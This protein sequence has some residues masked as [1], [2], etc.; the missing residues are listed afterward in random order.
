MLIWFFPFPLLHQVDWHLAFKLLCNPANRQTKDTDNIPSPH[1]QNTIVKL[2]KSI[3]IVGF[4][5]LLIFLLS[6]CFSG[7]LRIGNLS[8]KHIQIVVLW[9]QYKCFTL[10]NE[11]IIFNQVS[12]RYIN[13]LCVVGSHIK[14]SLNRGKAKDKGTLD[15][16]G[17]SA[18]LCSLSFMMHLRR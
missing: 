15:M 3:L 18:H 6:S 13:A 5:L 10:E 7:S 1:F 17:V 2:L 12:P 16:Q 14:H 11:P 4:L 9:H 8:K